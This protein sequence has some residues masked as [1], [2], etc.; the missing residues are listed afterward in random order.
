MQRDTLNLTQQRFN[1][2]TAS[3]LEVE[4]LRNQVESTDAQI[5]PLSASVETYLNALAI[6]IGEAPGTLDQRSGRRRRCPC[7]PRRWQWVIRP[8]CCNADPTSAPPSAV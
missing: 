2:G 5:L 8:R 7:R 4:R 3:Q 1:N 6:L